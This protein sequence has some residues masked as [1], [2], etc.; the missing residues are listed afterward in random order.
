MSNR[1]DHRIEA[2]L[3]LNLL[4]VLHTLIR[5]RSTTRT[6][7]WLHI[8]QPSVSRSLKRLRE[9]FGD[10]LLRKTNAGM[11]L[12]EFASALAEPL[13]RWLGET[14]SLLHV[15]SDVDPAS[16]TGNF[17]I[18]STDYGVLTVLTPA[19]QTIMA[20]APHVRIDV[21]P[22]SPRSIDELALGTL[23]I[24][25]TG[26]D[27]PPARA[28]DK[29]LYTENFQCVFRCDHPLANTTS[30][31][32]SLEEFVHWPHIVAEVN[33]EDGDPVLQRLT[34]LGLERRIAARLPYFSAAPHILLASDAIM[35]MPDRAARHF[36]DIGGLE[37]K[38]APMELEPFDYWLLW[39]E[40]TRRDPATSW[41]ID[42]MSEVPV[43]Q[44][45]QNA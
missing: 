10:P 4:P 41:L 21:V 6:A 1:Q 35:V 22:L 31:K 36:C 26:F 23:D 33:G 28:Y 25:V 12:T 9:A 24:V 20:G 44:A 39:H 2:A 16:F 38:A 19:M 43:G 11:R 14:R 13:E 32:L 45:S 17:R 15:P 5:T 8:S 18:A 30:P 3:D 40:R 29:F 27:P 37:C 34:E 7:E 42:R